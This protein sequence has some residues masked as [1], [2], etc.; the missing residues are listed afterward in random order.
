MK[1]NIIKFSELS[2]AWQ[3][4]AIENHDERAQEYD[5]IEPLPHHKPSEHILYDL[6]QVIYVKKFLS[7]LVAGEQLTN[8][9]SVLYY[10][11]QTNNQCIMK[12]Q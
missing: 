11:D 12:F 8:N 2:E 1:R 7:L 3:A 5:Y 6:S 10:I 4:I 9:S